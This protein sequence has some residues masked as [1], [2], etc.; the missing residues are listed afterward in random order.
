M[1]LLAGQ[2]RKTCHLVQQ[3]SKKTSRPNINKDRLLGRIKVEGKT[4]TNLHMVAKTDLQHGVDLNKIPGQAYH[5]VANR[6]R[7]L[8]GFAA[9]LVKREPSISYTQGDVKVW[10]SVVI[11]FDVRSRNKKTPK[12]SQYHQLMH[13][14]KS[15]WFFS[16]HFHAE[17]R[18]N[19]QE[20]V[21]FCENIFG[22]PNMVICV[23]L[24][25][26]SFQRLQNLG[27][28]IKWFLKDQ[29]SDKLSKV[30]RLTSNF[31][32]IF[33]LIHI[34]YFRNSFQGLQNKLIYNHFF[35]SFFMIYHLCKAINIS[36]LFR[37]G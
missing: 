22:L 21:L 20:A 8:N 12:S 36:K 25:L 32:F 16:K 15:W 2:R 28:C 30:L 31:E 9:T 29:V 26:T 33:C 4:G 10:D 3:R 14:R 27:D 19:R 11:N 5:R 35:F 1:S 23:H 6:S 34:K 37:T 24:G 18:C 7:K 13:M 17:W